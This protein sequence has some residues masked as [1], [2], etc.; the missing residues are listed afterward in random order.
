MKFQ[1]TYQTNADYYSSYEK[2]LQSPLIAKLSQSK[3]GHIIFQFK[4]TEHFVH[5]FAHGKLLILWSS[6]EEKERCYSLLPQV[7][8]TNDG[9]PVDLKPL[10]STVYSIPYQTKK[11]TLAWC[12]EKVSY[13]RKVGLWGLIDNWQE[14]KA[15]EKAEKILSISARGCALIEEAEMNEDEWTPK[16][17]E[18]L[19]AEYRKILRDS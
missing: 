11:F 17:H 8:V 16:K 5:L 12:R 14:R 9:S 15:R 2:L 19:V 6:E 1:N 7:L 13:V 18:K 10:T 3:K 4:N